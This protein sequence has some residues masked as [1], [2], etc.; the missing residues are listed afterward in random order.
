VTEF[1]TRQLR[2]TLGSF[3]TGV[4]VITALDADGTP[5]AMTANSFSS[6]SLDP[7]LVLW[8]IGKDALAFDAFTQCKHFAIHVLK[9]DQQALSSRFATREARTFDDLQMEHGVGGVPLFS[10]YLSRFQCELHECLPG[11]DH[12]IVI[13]KVVDIEHK[14][15]E[16]LLFFSGKYRQLAE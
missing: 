10:D 13:G 16:P 14:E 1:D 7:P 11:G 15:G 8:S 2:N 5:R 9:Q 12:I 3:A 4:T 6:V